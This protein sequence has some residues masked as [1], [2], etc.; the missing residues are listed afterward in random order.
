MNDDYNNWTQNE[1]IDYNKWEGNEDIKLLDE[2]FSGPLWRRVC[3]EANDGDADSMALMENVN[4][5][6]ASLLFHMQSNTDKHRVDYELT[7]FR[8][9]ID[10]FIQ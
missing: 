5:I 4:T 2:W 9:V 3:D 10:D 1:N 7:Q 6:L 8:A